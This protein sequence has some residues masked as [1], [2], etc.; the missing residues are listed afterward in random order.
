MVSYLLLCGADVDLQP[1]PAGTPL[2]WAAEAGEI[3]M[4]QLFLLARTPTLLNRRNHLGQTALF[5]SL[6]STVDSNGDEPPYED[7]FAHRKATGVEIATALVLA[8]ADVTILDNDGASPLDFCEDARLAE[9]ML[10]RGAV[11]TEAS[12]V[13]A[14]GEGKLELV[15]LYASRGANF[16]FDNG[17]TPLIAACQHTRGKS[18]L[19]NQD[20]G[21]AGIVRMILQLPSISLDWIN[22]LP[23]SCAGTALI[24]AAMSACP[25]I[26]Q[27]LVD[28]GAD[29]NVPDDVG[30]FAVHMVDTAEKAR[31]LLSAGAND[32]GDD[33]SDGYTALMQE[34]A[35]GFVDVVRVLLE[36]GADINAHW[37]HPDGHVTSALSSTVSQGHV[38]ILQVLLS[39]TNPSVDVHS[40]PPGVTP[41][42]IVAAK[43][44]HPK[45]AGALI[46]ALLAAGADPRAT[47]AE[48]SIALMHCRDAAAVEKLVHA[49]PDTMRHQ[50]C[51]GRTVLMYLCA[52]MP[53]LVGFGALLG[54]GAE[55]I[56]E[57]KLSSSR[58]DVTATQA[59]WT[60]LFGIEIQD[61]YG[62]TALHFAMLASCDKTVNMLVHLG[63]D[64]LVCG[65]EGTT[66]LMKPFLD[67]DHELRAVVSANNNGAAAVDTDEQISRC[68]RL[69]ISH[70]LMKNE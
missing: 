54:A 64:V 23:D 50:N 3:A 7:E 22:Y 60:T 29:L 57:S 66:V 38:D 13:T 46:E 14:C 37:T 44:R 17:L 70:L 68:L 5:V 61:K 24:S 69:I 39:H 30:L 63:A 8:G 31:I 1:N 11:I 65:Y 43:V 4:V 62:D 33:Y 27:S 18:A 35:N 47:D 28:A 40:C 34:C 48:G 19:C 2:I 15:S 59:C 49:A 42:L 21:Y 26:L 32:T 58:D 52:G 53:T 36:Y 6:W 12:I 51:D 25:A 16:M 67:E 56:D 9:L 55:Y 41:I 45:P 20:C 10:E